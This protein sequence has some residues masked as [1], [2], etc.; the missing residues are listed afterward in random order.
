[1]EA[2]LEKQQK[3]SSRELDWRL[4]LV[5]SGP[6]GSRLELRVKRILISGLEETGMESR[7]LED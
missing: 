2:H 6:P 5:S 4:I 7:E 1:M 3:S